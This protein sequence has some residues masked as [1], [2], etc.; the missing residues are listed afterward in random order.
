MAMT[1]HNT[2]GIESERR[3][4]PVR[5]VP[6]PP[7]TKPS[8]TF[9][10]PPDGR[11][12]GRVA[13]ATRPKQALLDDMRKLVLQGA[14]PRPDGLECNPTEHSLAVAEQMVLSLPDDLEMPSASLPDDGE[15]TLSWQALDNQGERWRAVLAIAPDSEVECFVRCRTKNRPVAHFRTN[16]GVGPFGLPDDIVNALRT[17]WRAA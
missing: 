12:E 10:T 17:H 1:A 8:D 2:A 16:A 6:L 13:I 14:D 7:D 11:P 15:I 3:T 9:N 4:P 5:L